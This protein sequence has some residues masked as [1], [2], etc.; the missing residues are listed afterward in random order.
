MTGR[1]GSRPAASNG[2]RAPA[3]MR[4]DDAPRTRRRVLVRQGSHRLDDPARTL[5]SAGS[6]A[7]AQRVKG[8][9]SWP[10]GRWLICSCGPVPGVQH[11]SRPL[12]LPLLG[13][14]QRQPPTPLWVTPRA[15][16]DCSR[17]RPSRAD[18]CTTGPDTEAERLRVPGQGC[19]RGDT[20]TRRGD[21]SQ[22]VGL[23][24]DGRTWHYL[25]HAS[26]L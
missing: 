24:T 23:V 17:W 20:L 21:P 11:R 6:G 4:P 22:R 5:L 10:K 16:V 18:V 13:G 26:D 9:H 12:P 15:Y 14:R 3:R 25:S 1:C 2:R 19:R 8:A 7:L